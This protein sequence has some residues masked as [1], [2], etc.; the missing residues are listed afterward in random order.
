MFQTDTSSEK[1]V[2][3]KEIRVACE[4]ESEVDIHLIEEMR[5]GVFTDNPKLKS[6]MLCSAK[7]LGLT[8]ENDEIKPDVIK[9]YAE[10]SLGIIGK[11]Y[12][13]CAVK[14]ETAEESLF[15]NIKCFYETIGRAPIIP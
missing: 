12:E 9:S 15:E 2:A 11:E 7:H 10:E 14:K 13:K 6:F 4:K 3:M 8:D 5:K 1:I